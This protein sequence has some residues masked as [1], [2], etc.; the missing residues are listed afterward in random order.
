MS[1]KSRKHHLPITMTSYSEE[2]KVNDEEID[3]L[4]DS[5][6]FD[7]ARINNYLMYGEKDE[8]RNNDQFNV[9]RR[10]VD[11]HNIK[12]K[13]EASYIDEMRVCPILKIFLF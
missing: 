9:Y 6:A 8:N 7:E 11:D 2:I 10:L 5:K 3:K 1:N 13:K 12:K 4:E